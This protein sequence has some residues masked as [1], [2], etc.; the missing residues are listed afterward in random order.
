LQGSKEWLP[1]HAC[2]VA[3]TKAGGP[4]RVCSSEQA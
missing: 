4:Q 2:A 1:L 3:N